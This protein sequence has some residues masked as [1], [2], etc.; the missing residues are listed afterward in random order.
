[1]EE[2]KRENKDTA[3][4]ID[5]NVDSQLSNSLKEIHVHVHVINYYVYKYVCTCITCTSTLNNS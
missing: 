3:K 1:M 4:P 2:T 5:A